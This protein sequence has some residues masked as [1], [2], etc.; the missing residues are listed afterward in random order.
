MLPSYFD[1]IFVHLGQKVRLRPELSPNFFLT[2][3]TNSPEPD[4]KSPAR[5]ATLSSL[6][7][8]RGNLVNKHVNTTKCDTQFST[9]TL[10]VILT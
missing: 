10:S 2:L 7:P 6:P 4:P 3:G 9:T 8:G 5:L 1:Y